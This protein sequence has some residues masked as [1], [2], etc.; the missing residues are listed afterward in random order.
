MKADTHTPAEIFGRDIRYLVPLFQRPYVWNK[1]DQWAPLWE[2]VRAVAEQALEGNKGYG[3]Q[4]IPRISSAPSSWN[5]SGRRACSSR[6]G[7][8]STGSS[9]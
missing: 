1:T 7:M 6:S 9:A 8:S 4:E 2:D 3:A 5:S